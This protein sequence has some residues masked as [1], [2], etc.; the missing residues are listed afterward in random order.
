MRFTE[1][2]VDWGFSVVINEELERVFWFAGMAP[3]DIVVPH[4]NS[5][6]TAEQTALASLC[7]RGTYYSHCDD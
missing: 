1:A 6:G 4:I 2:G 5:F 7:N 3:Y